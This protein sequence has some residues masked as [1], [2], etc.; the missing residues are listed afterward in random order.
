MDNANGITLMISFS[1]ILL[2]VYKNANGFCMLHLYLETLVRVNILFFLI[3]NLKRIFSFWLS[4]S[5]YGAG[6]GHAKSPLL[7]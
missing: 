4:P 3:P 1:A 2:L 7:C 6:C 5:Q